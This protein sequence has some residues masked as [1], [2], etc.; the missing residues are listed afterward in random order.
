MT[1]RF[2]GVLVAVCRGAFTLQKL[3]AAVGQDRSLREIAKE[4]RF[5]H[6]SNLDPEVGSA[7]PSRAAAAEAPA[8]YDNLSNGFDPQGDQ[9]E[10]PTESNVVPSRSFNDNRFVFEQVE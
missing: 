4:A 9:Y 10:T 3:P 2:S 8:A 6:D 5:T 1:L 7:G